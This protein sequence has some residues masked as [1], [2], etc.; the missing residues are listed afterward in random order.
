MNHNAD[1]LELACLHLLVQVTYSIG[2]L[3]A[4]V[5]RLKTQLYAAF[6]VKERRLQPG[7]TL[8]SPLLGS[9][10]P[11]GQAPTVL[12]CTRPKSTPLYI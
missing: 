5:K 7:G 1:F 10:E 9:L 4:G 11:A 6:Y 3:A 12:L 2:F 8:T